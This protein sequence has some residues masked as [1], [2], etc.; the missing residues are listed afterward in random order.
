MVDTGRAAR[1][2]VAEEGLIQIRDADALAAVAEEVITT[3]VEAVPQ[4]R[5]GNE[6]VLRFLVGQV[7]KAT[8]GKADPGLAAGLMKERL[9]EFVPCARVQYNQH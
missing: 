4:Y 7:M 5:G 9:A 6:T 8:E 2:I 3:H 1:E